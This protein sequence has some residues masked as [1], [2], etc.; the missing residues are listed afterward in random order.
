MQTFGAQS[1]RVFFS[2]LFVP[3]AANTSL[4][5]VESHS[6]RI[7]RLIRNEKNKRSV[8]DSVNN[9]W[10]LVYVTLMIQNLKIYVNMF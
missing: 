9:F 10:K 1:Q 5:I 7:L 6:F 2:F 4:T 8:Y 3:P